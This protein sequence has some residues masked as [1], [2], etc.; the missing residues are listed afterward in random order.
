MEG[1][2]NGMQAGLPTGLAFGWFEVGC[3]PLRETYQ[4]LLLVWCERSDLATSADHI[5]PDI[6]V[7]GAQARVV[8][9]P[10]EDMS[11]LW[12]RAWRAVCGVWESCGKRQKPTLRVGGCKACRR[13]RQA[14]LPY[15][16]PVLPCVVVFR[17]P[18][19]GP[20][21]A[22]PASN[23]EIFR[24]LPRLD[25]LHFVSAQCTGGVERSRGC[26]PEQPGSVD[27]AKVCRVDEDGRSTG[28]CGD[29]LPVCR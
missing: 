2:A 10:L 22:C 19:L 28:K 14:F 27:P 9:K 6:M 5:P 12:R 8:D 4:Y 16:I 23:V 26:A 13:H 24:Q 29:I 1:I 17:N 18:R 11:V 15:L 7:Q 20:W 25:E 21:W 3:A